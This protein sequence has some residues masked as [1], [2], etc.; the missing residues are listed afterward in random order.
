MSR[1]SWL[2]SESERWQHDGLISE[3]TRRAILA[4]YP[5]Q[6]ADPSRALIPLAVLTAGFGV[7]LVNGEGGSVEAGDLLCVSGTPGEAKRQTD[8]D[9]V[10]DDLVRSTTVAKATQSAVLGSSA[11][12]VACKHVA[13]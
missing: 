2:D 1:E 11:V 4:R 7:V 6:P 12:L 8:A 9:G 5:Q 13:C 10:A 3:D